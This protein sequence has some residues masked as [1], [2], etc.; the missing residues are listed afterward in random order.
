[1]SEQVFLAL[2][3]L[4]TTVI[5]S[6]L[7]PTVALLINNRNASRIRAFDAETRKQEKADEYLRADAV[8]ARRKKES[9]EVA[10][11][12]KTNTAALVTTT[13][14]TQ[15]QIREV[16][17]LVNSDKTDEME[18]RL[19]VMQAALVSLMEISELVKALGRP[20]SEGART[21]LSSMRD[22]IENLT[23]ML[24]ERRKVTDM[25]TAEKN[26]TNVA[27]KAAVAALTAAGPLAVT[28]HQ[29]EENPVPVK[30]VPPA[31]PQQNEGAV[32]ETGRPGTT[33][34]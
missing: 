34:C 11:L 17:H 24:E 4:A 3:V 16:H 22:R 20:E 18:S 8:E 30:P 32:P 25:A 1:M 19:E 12:L 31:A 9:D 23:R 27:T 33:P 14:E 2:I 28:I 15:G 5:V 7:V 13:G 29:E 10:S 26:A 21:R 6:A